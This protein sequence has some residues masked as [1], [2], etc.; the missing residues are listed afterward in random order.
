MASQKFKNVNSETVK[1]NWDSMT[2]LCSNVV[3]DYF[4]T[5]TFNFLARKNSMFRDKVATLYH[6]KI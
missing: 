2:I 6:L 4:C 3:T 1:N 5:K